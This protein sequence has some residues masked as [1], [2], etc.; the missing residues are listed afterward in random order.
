MN[1]KTAIEKA[2]EALVEI[3][4]QEVGTWDKP[5][6]FSV[7]Y[8]RSVDIAREALAA[9]D[10]E[11]PSGC[12][13]FDCYIA[14]SDCAGCCLRSDCFPNEPQVQAFAASYHAEQC[15]SC[16]KWISVKDRLPENCNGVLVFGINESGKSRKAKAMYARKFELE[17]NDEAVDS[18]FFEYDE[19]RDESYVPEG[20]YEDN[21]C[22]E[23]DYVIDFTVTHW[24]PLPESPI[25]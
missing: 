14:S 2:R 8:R 18:G 23:T 9:L 4:N 17:A 12:P 13:T 24:Q 15:K 3:A 21:S 11:K 1:D 25:V 5:V 7:L 16:N 10:A 19:S 22:S 6:P 20:W